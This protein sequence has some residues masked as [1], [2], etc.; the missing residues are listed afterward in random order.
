MEKGNQQ[1]ARLEFRVNDHILIYILPH[2]LRNGLTFI[3]AAHIGSDKRSGHRH[4]EHLVAP[5][6]SSRRRARPR[7]AA[8]EHGT[9]GRH[10]TSRRGTNTNVRPSQN[11][12]G[13]S[14]HITFRGRNN[15]QAQNI[16]PRL[17]NTLKETIVLASSFHLQNTLRIKFT[18]LYY[19]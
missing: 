18:I 2:P 7:S 6:G 12:N 16:D 17:D 10:P 5:I 11:Y 9:R 3:P 13:G 8:E 1:R 4:R 14:E 19:I 15:G